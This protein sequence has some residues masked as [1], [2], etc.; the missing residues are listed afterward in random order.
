MAHQRF[1]GKQSSGTFSKQEGNKTLLVVSNPLLFQDCGYLARLLLTMRR[2]ANHLANSQQSRLPLLDTKA[3]NLYE[4]HQFMNC[5][6]FKL[7]SCRLLRM[8]L[9]FANAAGA[10]TRLQS[11]L[12]PYQC[13][14]RLS[15]ILVV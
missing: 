8:L 1:C 12:M 3:N 9:M 15:S 13:F 2:A 5:L 7:S 11:L 6:Q 4:Y 14:G 10:P